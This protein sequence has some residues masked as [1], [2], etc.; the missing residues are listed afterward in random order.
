MAQI[1]PARLIRTS[2]GH[3]GLLSYRNEAVRAAIHGLKYKR[4]RAIAPILAA[5][6]R[7]AF[8]RALARYA[9]AANERVVIVPVPLS[10]RR[11][12]ERGFNQ[13]ELLARA[14]C[15][16]APQEC[17]VDTRPLAR[18]RHT[19]PQTEIL[20]RSKRIDNV[21]RCFAARVPRDAD[22]RQLVIV[23]DDVTTTGATLTEGCK[24]LRAAG[25]RRVRG[26]ALAH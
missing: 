3:S 5:H 21:A 13:T 15:A 23:L 9:H 14:L 18:T 25:F 4:G 24:A 17:V 19:T 22:P 8:A 6:A 2:R 12:R 26:V 10:R 7:L 16:E 11:K 1:P 20:S